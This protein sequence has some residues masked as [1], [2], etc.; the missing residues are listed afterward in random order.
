MILKL[1]TSLRDYFLSA[2]IFHHLN[3]FQNKKVREICAKVW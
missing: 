1:V 2:L 3:P